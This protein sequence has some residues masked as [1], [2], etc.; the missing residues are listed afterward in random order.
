MDSNLL[1]PKHQL[2]L[3]I[4][5]FIFSSLSIIAITVVFVL[6]NKFEIFQSP[7]YKLIEKILIFDYIY[8]IITWFIC[9]AYFLVY[10]SDDSIAN[11]K[12]ICQIEGF[13]INYT[14]IAAV[15]WTS[16]VC[17]NLYSTTM[18]KDIQTYLPYYTT[19]GFGLP[20]IISIM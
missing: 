14:I 16:I 18:D 2:G 5:Y 4:E 17:H 15:F 7:Q 6:I 20:A 12:T 1:T 10:G 13:V 11:H 19:I 9:F 3:A 8:A